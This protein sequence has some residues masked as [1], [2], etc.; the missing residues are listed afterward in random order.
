M[1]AFVAYISATLV[2]TGFDL[3][4]LKGTSKE[5]LSDTKYVHNDCGR[6]V[7]VDRTED[8]HNRKISYFL[9]Y[10][11]PIRGKNHTLKVTPGTYASGKDYRKSGEKVCFTVM[12]SQYGNDSMAYTFLWGLM[13]ITLL[14]FG[15][16]T[17]FWAKEE[18]R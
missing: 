12:D 3:I 14:V 16:Q 9:T 13:I 11:S 17:Y 4:R 1:L 10:Y 18:F 2:F 15:V 5:A 8:L 7:L 6:V